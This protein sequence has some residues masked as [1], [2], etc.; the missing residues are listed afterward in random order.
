MKAIILCNHKKIKGLKLKEVKCL[1]CDGKCYTTGAGKRKITQ[2]SHKKYPTRLKKKYVCMKC[3]KHLIKS[4]FVKAEE[5]EEPSDFG[6][7]EPLLGIG[8]YEV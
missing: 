7:V 1:L 8:N 2:K 6:L 5:V 4:F 3:V